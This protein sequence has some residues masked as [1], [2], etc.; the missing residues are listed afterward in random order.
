MNLKLFIVAAI[1]FA[2]QVKG[3]AASGETG[4]DGLAE[5]FARMRLSASSSSW[6]P[7]TPP[8]EE[9]SRPTFISPLPKPKGKTLTLEDLRR[10]A[11][12]LRSAAIYYIEGRK[13]TIDP[14]KNLV[15]IDH[16]KYTLSSGESSADLV[17]RVLSHK[18]R[19]D[20]I[21][22]TNSERRQ[23]LIAQRRAAASKEL[24]EKPYSLAVAVS[25]PRSL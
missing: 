4:I 9:E 19:A 17:Y 10:G 25:R 2:P 12:H 3:A 11:I 14:E 16:G 15:K 21:S 6:A 8:T 13:V 18:K 22:R 24:R 7:A 23:R 5:S 1:V 20:K